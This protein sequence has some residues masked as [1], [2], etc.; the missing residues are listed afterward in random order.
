MVVKK[1]KL[2]AEGG[3]DDRPKYLPGKHPK[4]LEESPH[5]DYNAPL[6][7]KSEL[8]LDDW[9]IPKFNRFISFTLDVLI[10]KYKD[11]FKDFIKLPSRKFHPQYYYKIQQPMSINEIKSRDYEYEDGP[12]NFLLDVELLTKNCQAYN[13][14]DSLIVKNSMQVVML[15]EYEVLKAKNLKRNYLINNEVKEKLLHYFNKLVDGTEKIINQALLGSLSPKNLD[16][17]VKLSEPFMELVDKD[18]LPDYYEIVHNPMAL[19]IVK[20]NLDIG[21]YSKIYDFIIDMLLIFQNAH[22]F[23]DPSALIYKDAT[24]LTNYFNHLIQKEFFPEL[25]DLNERGEI[26]LEFDKFEFENYLAIGGGPAAAGALAIAALDNDIEPES[27]R[28]DFIDQTDYDFNHFEGLGNGYN[29]SLLTEDYLLNPNNFKRSITKPGSIIGTMPSDVK[30]ERSMTPNIEKTNSLEGEQLKIPKY[31]IIKSIQKERQLLSEQHTMEYKPYK[32]IHQIYIFSSKN[33]YSQAT[34]PLPGSRPSCNQN[35]VEYIFNGDELSQN[36]NAFSFMLQPMQTFLTLQSH[37]N[38]PLKNTET[39][40][41]INKE[42]VKSR[43]SNANSNL[44]QPQQQENNVIDNDARQD[45]ENLAN[46]SSNTID[47]GNDNDKY[48]TPEIF[49]IRLS[50]GLNHLVFKCEDKISN[51][52]ESMNFWIN[53]LP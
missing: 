47:T 22:I 8:F 29:R 1:R 35:W 51:E 4:N 40:L 48:N 31:N 13:E 33:L 43:N 26:N 52:V 21:Q 36:E 50:E 28:E 38:S 12:G 2:A 27:N 32:L 25:Q 6:N 23:N 46:S 11:T 34:K 5:V 7:P 18:E 9:H 3:N 20:Q 41:T 14:Y 37:L 49:D 44:S 42:P 10:D 39:L 45:M 24:T 53:V 30:N 19:S 17:K 16:D 15:I